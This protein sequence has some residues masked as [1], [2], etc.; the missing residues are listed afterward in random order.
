MTQITNARCPYCK[1]LVQ[2]VDPKTATPFF[3]QHKHKGATCKGSLLG[4]AKS[5]QETSSS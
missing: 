2:V 4:V 3:V 5:N 1:Q